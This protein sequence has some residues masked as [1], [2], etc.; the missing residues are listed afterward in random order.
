MAELWFPLVITQATVSGGFNITLT[1]NRACHLYLY[2]TDKAPWVHNITRNERGLLVP[3]DAY[4]CYVVWTLI[5][6]NEPGDTTTHTYS[7]LGWEHCQTKYFRFHGTIASNTSPSDSPIFHKHY[8]KP[9][10]PERKD[11]LDLREP[12]DYSNTRWQCQP[13]K[14]LHT[15]TIQYL[16]LWFTRLGTVRDDATIYL[17]E[18]DETHTPKRAYNNQTGH[19]LAQGSI[20]KAD[21]N[22]IPAYQYHQHTIQ[23]TPH[24][25]VDAATW[26]DI[27]KRTY[28][29]GSRYYAYLAMGRASETPFMGDDNYCYSNVANP[30]ARSW[31]GGGKLR[32]AYEK[33]G[34]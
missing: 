22:A 19:I 13:F 20:P 24:Y 4:W 5:D 7:W 18:A 3:W 16:K 33:W 2:W 11:Y 27:V 21:L 25:A 23:L 9:A 26:Y 8:I 32:I 15:E 1:T 10:G 12:P 29:P 30:A 28:P 14:P 6:Q 34:V 17:E 31:A